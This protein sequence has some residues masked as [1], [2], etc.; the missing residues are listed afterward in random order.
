MSLMAADATSPVPRAHVADHVFAELARDVLTGA[1][2]HG[3][4]LPP[5][6]VLVD[7]FG[8]SRVLVRQA[9]HR[10][11]ELGLVRVKQGGATLVLDPRTATDLRVLGLLYR[12]SPGALSA[13]DV[14]DIV[15]KQYMQGLSIVEVAGRRAK[16]DGALAPVIALLKEA[17]D[18][19]SALADFGAFERRFWRT[20][21]AAAGNRIFEM[22]LAW[23]YDA[24][25][26]PPV[27]PEVAGAR[28]QERFAFYVELVG[29]LVERGGPAAVEYYLASV[30]PI[31]D[32]V[33]AR[34][35]AARRAP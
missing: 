1:L 28:T 30:R 23:W 25:V 34:A 13:A 11:A 27:P 29:R 3:E 31:L 6:R 20:L 32:L 2:P 17:A 18:D 16:G 7:R 15:E 21:A 33:I 14:A 12:A 24:L 22:E 35:S 10:L 26:D 9:V 4:A 8:V 19:P 5:E